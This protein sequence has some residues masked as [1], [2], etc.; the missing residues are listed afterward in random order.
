MA[1]NNITEGQIVAIGNK[2]LVEYKSG[3]NKTQDIT[4]L[5][6]IVC[7]SGTPANL[8]PMSYF[9]MYCEYKN[10]IFHIE[11]TN[12]EE[13]K[14][15]ASKYFE[16]DCD[17]TFETYITKYAN[18]E[19]VMSIALYLYQKNKTNE[20]IITLRTDKKNTTDTN[21]W[22]LTRTKETKQIYTK[23]VALRVAEEGILE[24]LPNENGVGI[25]DI[26][27]LARNA[28]NNVTLDLGAKTVQVKA[29]NWLTKTQLT[30]AT[31]QSQLSCEKINIYTLN[32]NAT[33]EEMAQMQD[34]KFLTK[35][36]QREINTTGNE[37]LYFYV[38]AKQTNL[39]L[40]IKGIVRE[41]GQYITRSYTI[42]SQS[43]QGIME[44]WCNYVAVET[45][46]RSP[47]TEYPLS[48]YTISIY[49]M[50]TETTLDSVRWKVKQMRKPKEYAFKNSWG[51]WETL[52]LEASREKGIEVENTLQEAQERIFE[53][54][55]KIKEY[56]V[57]NTGWIANEEQR[58]LLT[59]WISSKEIYEIE[60]LSIY[61]IILEGE[62]YQL[63]L[64][65]KED[66]NNQ[67]IKYYRATTKQS[68]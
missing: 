27:P 49:N 47:K 31:T 46:F 54:Q 59:E 33:D 66:L 3:E 26:A 57:Q 15:S 63:E 5:W 53:T 51:V 41:T 68:V 52:T 48:E 38:G 1:Y 39:I 36:K 17:F 62:K 67:Q 13:V 23:N 30:A 10:N 7:G 37:R 40:Y 44:L 18:S 22:E 24:K 64:L 55:K 8:T 4:K 35:C 50:D 60:E 19:N 56:R 43:E 6:I 20:N 45:L 32:A 58:K 25:F 2:C 65:T 28:S 29:R 12:A 14:Q 9:D 42:S 16:L 61:R 21:I 34:N 11:G